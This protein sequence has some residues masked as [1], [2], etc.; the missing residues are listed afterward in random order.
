[1]AGGSSCQVLDSHELVISW[2]KSTLQAVEDAPKLQAGDVQVESTRRVQASLQLKVL[3]EDHD[4]KC[5]KGGQT[6]ISPFIQFLRDGCKYIV[7]TCVF[8]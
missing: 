6:L 7:R 4:L 5:A 1:M 8:F 2:L 3:H